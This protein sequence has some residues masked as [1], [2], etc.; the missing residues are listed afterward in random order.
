MSDLRNRFSAPAN[1]VFSKIQTEVQRLN[2]TRIEPEH[3]MLVLMHEESG[4]AFKALQSMGIDLN[5][6][7]DMLLNSLNQIEFPDGDLSMSDETK[8]I[9]GLSMDAVATLERPYLGTEHL[10]MALMRDLSN[11]V[12]PIMRRIGVTYNDL[13]TSIGRAPLEEI[14]EAA[15]K[16]GEVGQEI[17]DGEVLGVWGILKRISLVFWLLLAATAASALAA[18]Y[19]WIDPGLAVFLFVTLGWVISVCLHEFGHALVGYWGGDQ[20]VIL[21]GYLTLNPIKYTHGIISILLPVIFLA[22]GGIG[23]PGGA[24]YINQAAIPNRQTRS[25]LSA[26]GPMVTG[27]LTLFL[28]MPFS[29]EWYVVSANQHPTFWAA[30]SFLVFVQVWALVINLLPFPGLD[31]FGIFSPYLPEDIR[32]KLSRLAGWTLFLLVMLFVMDTPVQHLFWQLIGKILALLGVD[33]NLLGLGM[34][35]YRFW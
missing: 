15:L 12:Y 3:V 21:R 35:L 25:S 29:T 19:Q 28:A 1:R 8:R 7:E 20:G 10:L 13:L 27:I 17:N 9:L 6:L 11:R 26:A 32:L 2:H 34:E 18:W 30:L 33:F 14:S 5:E 4:S 22:L 23:L 24:V 16:A 31:G